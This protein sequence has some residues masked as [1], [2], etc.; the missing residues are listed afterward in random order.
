ME[1]TEGKAKIWMGLIMALGGLLTALLPR[2]VFALAMEVALVYLGLNA[3]YTFWQFLR[4]R[5]KMS[6][7]LSLVSFAFVILLTFFSFIPEWLIRV[8]FAAYCIASGLASLFQFGLDIHNRVKAPL[9]MGLAALAYIIIGLCLLFVPNF[10][11]QQLIAAFGI[12]LVILG[13]RYVA[14]GFET[15]SQS[16]RYHWKR[17]FRMS[18]PPL[19]CAFLP[20]QALSAINSRLDS[21]EQHPVIERKS[22]ASTKLKILVFTGPS[23]LQKIGH[24]ALAYD[25]IVYSYGNYDAESFRLK[26]IYGDGTYF[27]VAFEEYLPNM[28]NVEHNS[29]FEYG[30]QTTPEQEKQIEASLE[31]LHNQ[32]YRWYSAIEREDGYAHPERYETDYP[33]RLHARTGAK[34]YKIK[35]GRFH[36]YWALGDNC[37]SFLDMILGSLG[38]DVLS[39]RGIISPGTYF[40]FL[41]SEYI[42]PGSP[43]IFRA[44][45][46]NPQNEKSKGQAEPV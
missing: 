41:Q 40:E 42:K 46:V 7:I 12:Y 30:I 9:S 29:I 14:D 18:L 44:V 13:C 28:M 36:T 23:A 21:G 38:A 26:Q 45:Y 15:M 32:S 34:F 25:G 1:R 22:E 3:V 33:S 27:N 43:V 5:R 6:L 37:A 20:E 31:Q 10:L 11:T 35:K 2:Q 17:S 16:G 19:L 4:T 24:I 39:M 8:G